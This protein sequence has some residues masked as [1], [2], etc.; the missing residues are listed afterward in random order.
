M[1][2]VEIRKMALGS[3]DLSTLPL[4]PQESHFARV[5]WNF[6][7][8]KLK[9][10]NQNGCRTHPHKQQ[11]CSEQW[12]LQTLIYHECQS[13]GHKNEKL[14][15]AQFELHFKNVDPTTMQ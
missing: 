12:L 1:F 11:H 3:N 4:T 2:R 13:V 14:E 9:D 5:L 15:S 6:F 10:A 8:L 7:L